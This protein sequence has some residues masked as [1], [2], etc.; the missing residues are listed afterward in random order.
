ML[1]SIYLPVNIFVVCSLTCLCTFVAYIA[2]IMDPDQAAPRIR[3]YCVYFH[4][5]NL[6]LC[7]LVT[8]KD[9]ALIAIS[10][11]SAIADKIKNVFH[12]IS[13]NNFGS[14]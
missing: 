5:K 13:S 12:Y 3:L 14:E 6:I 2:N 10:M 8:R 9:L 4:D 1:L 11:N 7:A